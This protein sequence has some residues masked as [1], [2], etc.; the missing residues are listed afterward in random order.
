MRYDGNFNLEIVFAKIK[1][2]LKRN[3]NQKYFIPHKRYVF[4]K[5]KNLMFL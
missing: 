4:D 1:R 2:K 5:Q 3:L